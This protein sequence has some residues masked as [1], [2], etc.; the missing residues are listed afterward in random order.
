MSKAYE[1]I[2][3]SLQEL[4]A[5]MEATGGANLRQETISVHIAPAKKYTGKDVKAIRRANG[6]TQSLLAAYLCVSKKTIEAWEANRNVPNGP[7]S[8]L[9]ELLERRVVS[10]TA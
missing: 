4:I 10:V 3:D 1:K 8:R 2:A 9:L 5:D 6:L 7:S